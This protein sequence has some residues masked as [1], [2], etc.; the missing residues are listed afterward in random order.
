[1]ESRQAR[2]FQDVYQADL[3]KTFVSNGL[4]GSENQ[5][6]MQISIDGIGTAQRYHFWVAWGNFNELQISHRQK[7]LFMFPLAIWIDR[8]S[9][10]TAET[11][12]RV[13]EAQLDEL[14]P[15]SF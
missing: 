13:I 14:S 10:P 11:L 4:V 3:Y 9:Q 2:I 15:G 5:L 1:L 7:D 12:L 8:Q 6:S